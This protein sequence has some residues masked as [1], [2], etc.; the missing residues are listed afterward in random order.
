MSSELPPLPD[1][2]HVY[3]SILDLVGDTPLV[4]IALDRTRGARAR[5]GE[6]R[7]ANPGG[8]VKD[9]ICLAMIEAA[10][11]DGRLGPGG[12]VVEPTSGNTGIGLALVAARRGYR[13]VL[14]MPASMSLERRALLEAFGAEVVLTRRRTRR[15]RAPSS[16]RAR[17]RRSTRARSCRSSSTTRRTRSVHADTTGRGD[18]ARDGPAR[19]RRVRRGRRHGRHDQRRRA[20]CSRRLIPACRVVAVEPE[21]CAT[22]SRGR[23]RAD[24]DPGPRRRLRPEELRPVRRRRGAHRHRR[25]RVSHEAASRARGGLLVGISSGAAVAVALDVARELGPGKNVVTVLPDTG[26]RYFSLDEYFTQLTRRSLPS[27]PRVLVVGVG[28]LGCPAALA[29]ARAGVDALGAR[30]RRRGRRDE[31]APADPVFATTTSASDKLDAGGRAL[32]RRARHASGASSSSGPA[33]C[34]TTRARSC[35]RSTSSLEGADNFATKFLAADAVPLARAPV[36]HGAAVR[37][38]A[39]A[40]AVGADG[41]PL[42]PLPVRGR[43]A[44][45]ARRTAPRPASWGP[46]SGFAGA[47]MADLAL[48]CRCRRSRLRSGSVLTYDGLDRP[49]AR[50]RGRRATAL[51]ALRPDARSIFDIDETRYTAAACA[52]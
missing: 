11:R 46:S 1:H 10:E 51:P 21:S 52:A 48:G 8:S 5:L 45:E 47:L 34:R 41:A 38:R 32:D 29:L 27:R 24:E 22:I 9:R 33:S 15:W 26:E 42:L 13:C 12:V 36:V 50:G 14:T 35:A 30:G 43:A 2:P 4:E 18:P 7:A 37:W 44:D 40:L 3:G 39:T 23:A 19:G 17:S 16:A 25:G 20:T 31:P 49:A 28:G 6:D